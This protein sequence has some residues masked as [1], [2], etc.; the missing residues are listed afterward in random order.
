MTERSRTVLA[1]AW[2]LAFAM[3]CSLLCI[4]PI[5]DIIKA[6]MHVSY[7]AV[8]FLFSLPLVMIVAIA[9]PGG[10]LG[11]RIG[12]RRAIAIGAVLMAIGAL[13]RG[14]STTFGSLLVCTGLFGVGFSVIFPNLP[15]LV[16]LWFPPEKVGTA[17]G[18][19][20][21]GVTVGGAT[22]LAVTLPVVF[23]LFGTLQ[24]TFFIL[25]LPAA[26][27]AVLWL[28]LARD[29]AGAL[30][31]GAHRDSAE[32]AERASAPL[33][34][35]G[36]VWLVAALLFLNCLHFFV[37]T[38][39]TPTLLMRKG[40]S[41]QIASLIA[42]SR[43]WFS[44]PAMFFMP[45]ASYRM[46]FRKPFMWGSGLLLIVASLSAIYTPA[47]TGWVLMAIVGFTTGGTFPMIL[48]LTT[49]L[50][51]RESAG[52]STGMVL[53]LGYT[54]AF[55]GP[56]VAGRILDTTG[57]LDLVLVLLAISGGAWVL[58]GFAMPETGRPVE[59]KN[60][61]REEKGTWRTRDKPE[62]MK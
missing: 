61:C 49:E 21:T 15:K 37:W 46:G 9:I 40:S 42:S 13:A 23:P 14:A 47:W 56:W 27:G 55:V 11:D 34:K 60:V 31:S 3:Y 36:H 43:G 18:F 50:F 10:R 44:I 17:T 52:A 33:W 62:V 2:L 48:A 4:P 7:A 57:S 24:S 19:V 45:W 59:W 39:W 12:T 35:N 32:G 6:E 22:A 53:S 38:A 5:V 58:V 16:G 1:C 54:A 26:L 8:G 41:G 20:T 29:P 30:G 51:P 28:I 25:G